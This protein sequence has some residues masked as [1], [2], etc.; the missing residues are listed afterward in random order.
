MHHHGTGA[1][2]GRQRTTRYLEPSFVCTMPTAVRC[3]SC[4]PSKKTVPLLA[5]AVSKDVCW[6]GAPQSHETVELTVCEE[7]YRQ[8]STLVYLARV[9]CAKQVACKDAPLGDAGRS[10]ILAASGYWREKETMSR[11]RDCR[12]LTLVGTANGRNSTTTHW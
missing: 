6:W 3:R 1:T 8:T 10:L 4:R 12:A 2:N 7:Q 11:D 9:G 5:K